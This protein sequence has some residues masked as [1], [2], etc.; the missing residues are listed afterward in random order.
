MSSS[1]MMNGAIMPRATQARKRNEPVTRTRSHAQAGT[2]RI[3]SVT[4]LHLGQPSRD[5]TRL[6]RAGLD[7]DLCRGQAHLRK[8]RV[9]HGLPA[10]GP[11]EAGR[12]QVGDTADTV[13]AFRESTR[14][15]A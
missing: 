14:S 5:L 1:T 10:R 3:L 4:E 8:H 11:L 9:G 12:V 7:A 2:P 15:G 13:N 6:R